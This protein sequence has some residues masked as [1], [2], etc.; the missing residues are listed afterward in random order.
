MTPAPA[1]RPVGSPP[2][3][4]SIRRRWFD[5]GAGALC[6]AG[7]FAA[8]LASA[9]LLG[10]GANRVTPAARAD[11]YGIQA[12]NLV[13]AE[14][15]AAEDRPLLAGGEA[16]ARVSR[17]ASPSVVHIESRYRDDDGAGVEETG[18]GVL[19]RH[20]NWSGTGEEG[21]LFVLTNRHVVQGGGT[22]G[23]DLSLANGRHVRPIRVWTDK[24]TD[25]AVLEID[26]L[27]LPAI[28]FGNSD[29][30]EIGHFVLALGSPFGLDRSVTLG[31]VSAKGRRRL[32]LGGDGLMNQDFLQTDAA[33]NPGNSGG[34]LLD[35]HGRLVGLNTAIASAGGGHEGVGFSIPANLVRRVFDELVTHNRVRR[36]YLGVQLDS[37]FDSRAAGRA[38]LDRLYGARV[39]M[40]KPDTPAEAAGLRADDVILRFGTREV[41]DLTHLIELVSLTPV[42]ERVELVVLR[43]R[44]ELPVTLT[45]DDLD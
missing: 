15:D 30:L 23:V 16:L 22:G 35:L 19:A 7:L 21:R 13:R 29:A 32:E 37:R 8:G 36:A 6:G 11:A 33:I 20:P 4:S 26:N 40:V 27:D 12:A 9:D 2:A 41:Q 25:I 31:I 3:S 10:P 38:G 5:R 17:L 44:R 34:P 1:D 43:D 45:L 42:G 14:L 28:R 39:R 24:A 18:S